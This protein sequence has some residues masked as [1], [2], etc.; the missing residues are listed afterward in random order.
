MFSNISIPWV[1]LHIL[2]LNSLYYLVQVSHGT[3]RNYSHSKP[4]QEYL[5]LPPSSPHSTNTGTLPP[6]SQF[7][8]I[9][10]SSKSHSV[11]WRLRKDQ[12]QS[13][14]PGPLSLVRNSPRS[15]HSQ[16]RW[17]GR[18]F[19][20]ERKIKVGKNV[21]NLDLPRWAVDI[22]RC[23]WGALWSRNSRAK[24]KRWRVTGCRGEGKWEAGGREGFDLYMWLTV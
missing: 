17:P 21:L 2:L 24:M 19:D 13:C 6:S 9:S 3:L 5:H 1:F 22:L 23:I 15:E 8:D 18:G 12:T 7:Y 10:N 4:V 11:S 20:L 16:C 14:L